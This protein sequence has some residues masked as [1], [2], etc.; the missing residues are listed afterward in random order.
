[1]T[2]VDRVLNNNPV[3]KKIFEI[4]LTDESEIKSRLFKMALE[5]PDKVSPKEIYE[6]FIENRKNIKVK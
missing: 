6:F 3:A 5:G 4:L 2:D 1:M